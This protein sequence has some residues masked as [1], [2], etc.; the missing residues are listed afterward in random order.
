MI[1]RLGHDRPYV[2]LAAPHGDTI[3][4]WMRREAWLVDALEETHLDEN[5]IG[6]YLTDRISG[7]L[8]D[9]LRAYGV[10]SGVASIARAYEEALR[11]ETRGLAVKKTL[12]Q[13][14]VSRLSRGTGNK[15][16]NEI[17]TTLRNEIGDQFADFERG[18][19]KRWEERTAPEIGTLWEKVDPLID[20]IDDFERED[21]AKATLLRIPE[22]NKS[23]ILNAVFEALHEECLA[24][25][26]AMRDLFRDVNRRVER[27]VQEADGPPVVVQ[28]DHVTDDEVRRLL[29][30]RVRTRR[31]YN[32][33]IPRRGF[34]EYVMGARR[35]QIVFYMMFSTLGFSF[36]RAYTEIMI[37]V[38]LVLLS[39]G[40]LG[41]AHTVRRERVEGVQREREKMRSW[42]HGEIEQIFADVR[43]AWLSTL[44]D[45]LKQQQKRAL[46]Q[47]EAVLREH[48]R[49]QSEESEEA[50]RSVQL[51]LQGLENTGRKLSAAKQRCEQ[52]RQDT[53]TFQ[54]QLRRAFDAAL[55][56]ATTGP[57]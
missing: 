10:A 24:D 3:M 7:A 30:A 6:E 15:R 25:L 9:V 27:I 53:A 54:N 13:Q 21:Q 18:V 51:Q 2:V 39:V 40:A 14:R 16:A 29:E 55:R 31:D 33:Q 1:T 41:V 20:D 34:Y 5:K 11:Q 17:L 44:N 23:H 56:D 43:R 19:A 42:L 46:P 12:T 52:V 38:T 8:R 35:Y 37:T 32:G 50:K 45:H 4:T 28:F 22:E 57:S 48:R 36:I 47:V 26:V 49:R